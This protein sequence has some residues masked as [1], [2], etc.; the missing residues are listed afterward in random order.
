MHLVVVFFLVFLSFIVD[1]MLQ[2]FN[3]FR[4]DESKETKQAQPH[5]KIKRINSF[6][7]KGAGP[8]QATCATASSAISRTISPSCQQQSTATSISK[9]FDD[10]QSKDTCA[11]G[12]RG[13]FPEQKKDISVTGVAKRGKLSASPKCSSSSTSSS[14]TTIATIAT[15]ATSPT[16]ARSTSS[17]YKNRHGGTPQPYSSRSTASLTQTSFVKKKEKKKEKEKKRG[18]VM[19]GQKS[20]NSFFGGS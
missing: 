5:M 19:K 10:A 8:L 7:Q 4:L 17:Q 3:Y 15:I 20:I 9:L 12:K 2:K 14:C 16:T 13:C 1:V 6:F 11:R 18:S